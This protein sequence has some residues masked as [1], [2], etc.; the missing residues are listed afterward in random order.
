MTQS[1]PTASAE[2]PVSPTEG[3]RP[4]APSSPTQAQTHRGALPA[5]VALTAVAL[6]IGGSVLWYRQPSVRV[7]LEPAPATASILIPAEDGPASAPALAGA[8]APAASVPAVPGP[9]DDRL[10][11]LHASIEQLTARVVA[12]EDAD[13]AHAEQVATLRADIERLTAERHAEREKAAE[14][15]RQTMTTTATRS[16][17][18]SRAASATSTPSDTASVLAVDLWGGQPSVVVAKEGTNGTE[19]RFINQGE[20]QGRVTLKRADVGSQRATFTT[21]SGELTMSAGE[22]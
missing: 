4:S 5:F 11:T 16:R 13:R 8:A 15:T 6:A 12:L 10:A 20:T 14:R 2:P 21:P 1:V 7:S 17:R 22:R 9:A 19:V 18:T 3:R